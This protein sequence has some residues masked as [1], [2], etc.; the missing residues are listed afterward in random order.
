[1]TVTCRRWASTSPPAIPSPAPPPPV[2]TGRELFA[3]M[4]HHVDM[5]EAGG[6]AILMAMESE[7]R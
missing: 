2:G 1:M 7:L 6:S 3:M 5:A 4:R